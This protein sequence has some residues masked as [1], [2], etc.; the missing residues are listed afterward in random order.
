MLQTCVEVHNN[1]KAN[2]STTFEIKDKQHNMKKI[3]VII[4]ETQATTLLSK[5]AAGAKK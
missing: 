4:M 3:I 2:D 5:Q 1:A